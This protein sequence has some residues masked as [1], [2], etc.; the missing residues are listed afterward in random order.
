MNS[1][2]PDQPPAAT[3]LARLTDINDES[4][5]VTGYFQ[6]LAERLGNR[7]NLSP[8]ELAD[9]VIDCREKFLDH[10]GPLERHVRPVAIQL[11]TSIV[12]AVTTLSTETPVRELMRQYN[13]RQ[14]QLFQ[15]DA[16]PVMTIPTVRPVK[17]PSLS[18]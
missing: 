13:I 11:E 16:E 5:M 7:K 18:L 8:R 17:G 12:A 10:L 3:L 4:R 9:A 14:E 1:Q 2:Y 6:P 15:L